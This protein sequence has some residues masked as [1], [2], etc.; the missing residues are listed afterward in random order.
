MTEAFLLALLL[1]A[2]AVLNTALSLAV[3]RCGL[4]SQAQVTAQ[5]ITIWLVPVFGALLVVGVLRSHQDLT[6]LRP[7]GELD[8]EGHSSNS[9]DASLVGEHVDA[10]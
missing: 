2:L 5:V 1:A 6:V 3:H 4:Y 10:A 8:R 9:A 7:T